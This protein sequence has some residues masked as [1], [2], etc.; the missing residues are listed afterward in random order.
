MVSYKDIFDMCCLSNRNIDGT[1]IPNDDSHLLIT[2]SMETNTWNLASQNRILQQ[3]D[4][5]PVYYEKQNVKTGNYLEFI[6]KD[7]IN[8]V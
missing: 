8:F 5:I 7:C 1:L 3:L 4:S 6:R 2:V